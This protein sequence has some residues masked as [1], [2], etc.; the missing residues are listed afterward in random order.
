MKEM[1]IGYVRVSSR[2]Q[3][4]D[5]QLIAMKEAGVPSKKIY[6]DKQSGKDFDRPQYK[7][8]LR[9]LKKDAVLY[10][11]SIDRLG[12]NYEE[13]IEQWRTITKEIGADIVV[14][15]MPLLDTRRGKDLMGTF[16]SDIVLQVLSFVAENERNAIRERQAEGIVAA[17]ERGV[18][19]GRPRTQL[20]ENFAVVVRK[21]QKREITLTQVCRLY[22]LPRSTAY[23][24]LVHYLYTEDGP[25]W[26]RG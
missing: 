14:L 10:I 17:K 24:Q 23:D 3:N 6:I 26:I 1:R 16:V 18:Q 7:R 9:A 25:N 8:M 19:F 15:D 13:I 20:P 12:R 11:K 5:R 4:E 22:N 21:W 2:E